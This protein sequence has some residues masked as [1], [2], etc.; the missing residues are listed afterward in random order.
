MKPDRRCEC[1]AN[2]LESG[3]YIYVRLL[4]VSRVR[5]HIPVGED[6]SE[7]HLGIGCVVRLQVCRVRAEGAELAE[8]GTLSLLYI[9]PRK[10]NGYPPADAPYS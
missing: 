9:S 4:A 1:G 5:A 6:K 8:S 7:R 2:V 10:L 3:K